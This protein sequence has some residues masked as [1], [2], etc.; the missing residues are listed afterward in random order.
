MTPKFLETLRD[1]NGD[2]IADGAYAFV[3]PNVLSDFA[4]NV[5]VHTWKVD[6]QGRVLVSDADNNGWVYPNQICLGD[7][8]PHMRTPWGCGGPLWRKVQ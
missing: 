4:H 1:I 6:E 2:E 8:P 3:I 5:I 7:A